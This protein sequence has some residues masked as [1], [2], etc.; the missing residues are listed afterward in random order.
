MMTFG[1]NYNEFHE[2]ENSTSTALDAAETLIQNDKSRI[3]ISQNLESSF[4]VVKDF[5]LLRPP[6]PQA[7][8]N[9]IDTSRQ[10]ERTRKAN[11]TLGQAASR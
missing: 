4:I 10:P 6:K 11:G 7:G 8:H 5:W 9:E 1:L 3:R 2:S